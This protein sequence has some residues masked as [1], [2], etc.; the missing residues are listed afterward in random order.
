VAPA[1]GLYRNDALGDCTCAAIA[2]ALAAEA[3]NTG[4]PPPP[5]RDADVV[6]LYERVSDYDPARPETDQGAQ[7]IDV[8]RAMRSTGMAGARIGAYAA[9]DWLS[10]TQ[11]EAAINLFGAVYLGI[12]LPLAWQDATTWDIAPVHGAGPDYARGSWGGHA[13]S[14][15]A[16]DRVGLTC[17]T[18]GALK[19]MTWEALRAYGSEAWAM[20]GPLWLRDDGL[21]PSGFDAQLLAQD[22]AAIGAVS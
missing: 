19:F 5:I 13:V 15:L 12:D 9:V 14:V 16:Y 7:M 1:W 2:H 21:T 8:L 3:A 11:V 18:W 22:L 10:R 17:V 4:R 20:I 6:E